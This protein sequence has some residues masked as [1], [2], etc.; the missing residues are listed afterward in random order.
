[1]YFFT[2]ILFLSLYKWPKFGISLN[3]ALIVI[4][5]IVTLY[6]KFLY[7]YIN[8]N[9]FKKFESIQQAIIHIT[10]YYLTPFQYVASFSIGSFF[11]YLMLKYPNIYLGGK[12][13]EILLWFI[14]ISVIPLTYIWNN[15]FWSLTEVPSEVSILL[16]YSLGRTIW[17]FAFGWFYFACS[18][19]R[20]GNKI[21]YS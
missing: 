8:Y 1:L 12:K 19:G 13:V 15:T 7:D 11:G 5:T 3:V 16:W 20:G 10:A 6:P 2:P 14:A 9:D 18:T 4:G 17:T 21:I